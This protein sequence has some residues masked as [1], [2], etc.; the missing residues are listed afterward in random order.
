N[1]P[2][3]I[4][5]WL[6]A[7]ISASRRSAHTEAVDHL[8]RGLDLLREIAQPELRRQL[9]LHLQVAL[10]GSITALRGPM[11]AAVSK[12][13]ESGLELC[14]EEKPPPLVFPFLFG[15]YTFTL[16]RAQLLEA[17]SLAELFLSLAEHNAYESGR[18]IAHRMMGMALLAQGRAR[19]AK[20]QLEQSLALYRHEH[21]A[22]VMRLFGE[23]NPQVRSQG[24]LSLTLFCIGDVDE[25]LQSASAAIRAADM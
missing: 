23:A 5:A 15:K 1:F 24:L 11:S 14:E 8:R 20:G 25:A 9:E 19:E 7:G 3:G 6:D 18:V 21:D 10:I 22:P 2:D 16:C 4:K 12:F 17:M 13:C